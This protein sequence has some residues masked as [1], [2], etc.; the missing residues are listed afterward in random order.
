MRIKA[1]LVLIIVFS[2]ARVRAQNDGSQNLW[3]GNFLLR[4]VLMQ[5]CHH[6]WGLNPSKFAS[7]DVRMNQLVNVFDSDVGLYEGPE[8]MAGIAVFPK[9]LVSLLEQPNVLFALR[10]LIGA[11]DSGGLGVDLWTW[12]YRRFSSQGPVALRFLAVLFQDSG[13]GEHLSYLQLKFG[14]RFN[15]AISLL[16]RINEH[17]NKNPTLRLYPPWLDSRVTSFYHFYV[18]GYA[19]YRVGL[20][21]KNDPMAT[22]VPFLFNMTYEF[23]VENCIKKNPK[24]MAQFFRLVSQ[25]PTLSPTPLGMWECLNPPAWPYPESAMDVYLGYRASLWATAK[26]P[27]F[28]NWGQFYGAFAPGPRKFVLENF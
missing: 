11:L 20:I 2:N 8:K 4:V 9:E 7:C 6:F 28:T 12:T 10:E 23:A 26:T 22:T 14:D 18:I 17:I 1:I 3:P 15:Y 13:F 5:R 24:N 25:A 27:K 19:A 16:K 21:S